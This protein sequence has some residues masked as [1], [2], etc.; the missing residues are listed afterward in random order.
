MTTRTA[1]EV[2][3]DLAARIAAIGGSWNLAP[4]P[5]ALHGPSAVPDA[6]PSTR[7]HLSF[8]V[9]LTASEAQKD[10]QRP[11]NGVLT[12]SRASIRFLAR[13][14]PKDQIM[15][16]DA[17]LDAE[18]ALIQQLCAV[19]G[20]WPATFHVTWRNSARAVF[21]SGEWF[22]LESQFDILHRTPLQ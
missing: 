20:S 2:R 6:I 16:E 13:L 14:T 21:P 15:S 12:R 9:G 4:V 3:Q 5:F 17:A 11:P 19:T 8:S 22:L 1:A 18:L 7:A 10:R